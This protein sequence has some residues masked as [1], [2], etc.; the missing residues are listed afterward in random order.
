MNKTLLAEDSHRVVNSW[1]PSTNPHWQSRCD[2]VIRL[3]LGEEECKC[4]SITTI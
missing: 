1:H 3:V 4:K 2:D